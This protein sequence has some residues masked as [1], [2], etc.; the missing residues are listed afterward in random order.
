[1]DFF[2]LLCHSRRWRWN[3]VYSSSY[4]MALN[5]TM[6]LLLLISSKVAVLKFGM[7]WDMYFLVS[8]MSFTWTSIWGAMVIKNKNLP[9]TMMLKIHLNQI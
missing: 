1:M 7:C 2:M 9:K 6:L 8:L 5:T 4:L 3:L